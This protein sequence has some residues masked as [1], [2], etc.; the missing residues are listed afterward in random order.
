MLRNGLLYVS[1]DTEFLVN[2]LTEGGTISLALATE[3]ET[4]YAVNADMDFNMAMRS[5]WLVD[6]VVR[7]HIPLTVEA[8]PG[9]TGV[10]F[11]DESHADV[12]SFR[13]IAADVEGFFDR[14]LGLVNYDPDQVRVVARCGAQDMVR[15]HTLWG[16]DWSLMPPVIPQF[17]DDVRRMELDSGLPYTSLPVQPEHEKHHALHDAVHELRVIDHILTHTKF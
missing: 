11:L 5:P 4:L 17:F 8:A 7:P 1:L 16:N 13:Q 14:A 3:Q 15:L 2:D 9:M 10:E 6:N 12:K